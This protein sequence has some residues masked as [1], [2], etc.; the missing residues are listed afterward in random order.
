MSE[1]F[2]T[3]LHQCASGNPSVTIEEWMDECQTV[4]EFGNSSKLRVARCSS[5]DFGAPRCA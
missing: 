5:G 1:G 2:D 3:P 4:K